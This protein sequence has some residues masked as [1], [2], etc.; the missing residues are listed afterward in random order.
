MFVL[1]EKFSHHIYT[2]GLLG[3]GVFMSPE[4]NTDVFVRGKAV[5]GEEGLL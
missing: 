5:H 2:L 1:V 3:I 4:V